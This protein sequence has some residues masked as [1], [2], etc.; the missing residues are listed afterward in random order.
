V[1]TAALLAPESPARVGAVDAAA[2]PWPS[3]RYS[4]EGSLALLREG[5]TLGLAGEAPGAPSGD[6]VIQFVKTLTLPEQHIF[7]AEP[8]QGLPESALAIKCLVIRLKLFAYAKDALSAAAVGP[9]DR[10]DAAFVA[11][12]DTEVRVASDELQ[13]ATAVYMSS[14]DTQRIKETNHFRNAL[15]RGEAEFRSAIARLRGEAP[16]QEGG[17]TVFLD[18]ESAPTQDPTLAPRRELTKAPEKVEK[19]PE[20]GKVKLG[21]EKTPEERRRRL[22]IWTG[23][24]WTVLGAIAYFAYPAH[25]REMD[26]SEFAE[27]G[28]TSAILFK[29]KHQAVIVVPDNWKVDTARAKKLDDFLARNAVETYVVRNAQGATL[30]LGV[31]SKPRIVTLAGTPTK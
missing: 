11:S 9:T 12:M 16:L 6:A 14:G 20:P 30:V 29:E 2:P 3:S 8:P 19:R 31:P 26:A 17:S 27:L 25:P 1:S 10:I 4:S 7:D 15:I 24:G 23:I 21:F 28:A 5:T 13:K 18:R 22:M